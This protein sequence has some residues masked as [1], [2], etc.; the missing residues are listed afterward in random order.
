MN[1]KNFNKNVSLIP[2]NQLTGPIYCGWSLS[3]FGQC[4]ILLQSNIVVGLAF[5]NNETENKIETA[6]KA[7]WSKNAPKFEPLNTDQIAKDIFVTDI[8][9][10]ISFSGSQLQAMVWKALLEIS[11]GETATYSFIA[12]K[13]KNPKAIRAVATAIGQNPIAW[14]IPCHRIIRKSGGLGGYRWGLKIKKLMLS[15]E[16]QI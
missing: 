10:N 5:K 3:P 4:Y 2:F 6:I 12:K 16:T 9:I 15:N 13:I 1:K 14:L 7:Q 11:R 8:R